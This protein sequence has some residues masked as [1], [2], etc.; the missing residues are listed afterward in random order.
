[1]RGSQRKLIRIGEAFAGFL[2][3]MLRDGIP[4][5]DR[6]RRGERTGRL[7]EGNK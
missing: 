6:I 4:K 7:Q 5:E 2:L 3:F 1:M